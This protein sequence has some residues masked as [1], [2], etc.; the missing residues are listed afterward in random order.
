M[1][2]QFAV[3][4]D[5]L[6]TRANFREKAPVRGILAPRGPLD[7][8]ATSI[9]EFG[10]QHQKQRARTQSDRR[11]LSKPLPVRERWKTFKLLAASSER[12]EVR[13]PLSIYI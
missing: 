4:S 6:A 8:F 7:L 13:L 1:P 11:S 3:E 9:F 5:R 12:D 10:R 2:L